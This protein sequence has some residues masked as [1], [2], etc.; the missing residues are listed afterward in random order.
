MKTD[1][2]IFV[3][4]EGENNSLMA[5]EDNIGLVVF[6]EDINEIRDGVVLK[7]DE[8]YDGEYK[9]DIRFIHV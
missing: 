3:V 6:G 4:L 8:Y 1:E 2:L 7:V 5:V 9:G